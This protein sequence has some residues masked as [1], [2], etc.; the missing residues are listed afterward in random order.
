[1]MGGPTV[2]VSGSGRTRKGQNLGQTPRCP[3]D[4]VLGGITC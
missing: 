3:L 1:M 2:S 4:A